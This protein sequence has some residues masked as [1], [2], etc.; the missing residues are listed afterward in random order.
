MPDPNDNPSGDPAPS[1]QPSPAAVPPA[2]QN[3]GTPP[4]ASDPTKMAEDLG[5]YKKAA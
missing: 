5:K 2:N 1:Q 4:P 3:G